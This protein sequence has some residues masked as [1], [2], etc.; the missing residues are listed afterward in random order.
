MGVV[1]WALVALYAQAHARA[2]RWSKRAA[3]GFGGVGKGGGEERRGELLC[4]NSLP[5]RRLLTTFMLLLI[6]GLAGT[7]AALRHGWPSIHQ[8]Q[9][10]NGVEGRVM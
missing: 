1:V 4:S 2:W 5:H 10:R 7:A 3:A 8:L 9:V 6:R